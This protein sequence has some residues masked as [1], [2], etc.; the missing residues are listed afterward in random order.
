M[1]C[2]CK[3]L[4]ALG[5]GGG[6]H[7]GGGHHGGG[8][9]GG[10]GHHGGGHGGG[11]WGRGGAVYW[12][13]DIPVTAECVYPCPPGLYGCQPNCFAPVNPGAI[14]GFGQDASAIDVAAAWSAMTE[15]DV[16]GERWWRLPVAQTIWANMASQIAVEAAAP[17]A[18]MACFTILDPPVTAVKQAPTQE[19][20]SGLI[21]LGSAVYANIV[22][23]IPSATASKIVCATLPKIGA[24]P[25]PSS[26]GAQ[27]AR[28]YPAPATLTQAPYAAAAVQPLPVYPTPGDEVPAVVQ[29]GAPSTGMSTETKGLIVAG[30]AVV[31]LGAI[32]AWSKYGKK[33][34]VPNRRYRG[35]CR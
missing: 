29:P 31:G 12:G 26:P 25:L 8:H 22:N 1:G 7:H 35:N 33:R 17:S 11:G 15:V 34:A 2:S 16:N 20:V 4:G 18:S 14:Y 9:G 13:N 27:F 5:G 32:W 24:A 3:G 21:Q 10:G 30:A 28:M 23:A 6:G 19:V